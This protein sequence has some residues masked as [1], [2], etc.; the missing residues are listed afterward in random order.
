MIGI[1]ILI[2]ALS[3]F[4]Y[5]LPMV[6][7]A[8][9]ALLVLIFLFICKKN[10]QLAWIVLLGEILLDGSGRFFEI[11]GLILRT[12]FL[13][14][15]AT[16]WLLHTFKRKKLLQLFS[17]FEI[18]LFCVLAFVFLFA[19]I[20]GLMQKH[21][22]ILV[23]QDMLLYGFV[24][25]IF[26][27][28]EFF[29]EKNKIFLQFI[30]AFVWGSAIFSTF[31]FA[32]YASG[33]GYLPD[34]YYH[35]FR[36]VVGGKI[37]DLGNDFFR[38]VT[39]EQLILVPIFLILTSFLIHDP[40][41][42]KSWILLFLTS[43]PLALNFTRIYFISIVV[44]IIILSI[45]NS[46]K[47]WF[48]VSSVTCLSILI[49][50]CTFSFAASKGNTLGLEQLG[51]RFAGTKAPSAETSGAIRLAILPDAIKTIKNHPW[52]GSGLGTTVTYID[53]TTQQSI[54]R[55]QFDWGYLEVIAELGIIGTLMFLF[56]LGYILFG[57]ARIGY[58]S[59]LQAEPPDP[60]LSRGLLAGGISLFVI[61]ITT[62]ALFQGFGILYFCALW[63]FI[64]KYSQSLPVQSMSK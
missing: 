6:N 9:G 52:I 4:T 46:F 57:V 3:F 16:F 61:N 43:I 15:F 50:F 64:S 62:P 17:Q 1:F 49:F 18:R 20:N 35:W 37:T 63:V 47:K 58:F 39:S 10:I 2:R 29:Q 30:H 26:P 24:A 44:G 56:F 28:M 21:A 25:L 60:T 27:A 40:K 41:N 23:I 45:K 55:T 54:T 48:M 42:K 14:I 38:I 19:T 33:I 34:T 59:K 13:G 53:P 8:L 5:H 51:L 7:S 11:Q 31:T 36:N 22:P 12:W 32:L